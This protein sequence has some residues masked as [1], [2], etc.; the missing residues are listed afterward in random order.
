MSLILHGIPPYLVLHLSRFLVGYGSETNIPIMTA[1]IY[2]PPPNKTEQLER[3]GPRR[4]SHIFKSPKDSFRGSC[5][6]A[7][8]Y[9]EA[10]IDIVSS[11][12]KTR[13]REIC[14]ASDIVTPLNEVA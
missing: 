8:S 10:L 11:R 9:G 6:N 14:R 1:G 12:K 4:E 3:Q 13:R 7:S 5:N 2:S